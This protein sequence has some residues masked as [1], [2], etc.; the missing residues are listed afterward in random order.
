MVSKTFKLSFATDQLDDCEN[1][2][3]P[4]LISFCG[5]VGVISFSRYPFGFSD[6][7]CEAITETNRSKKKLP[8]SHDIKI[9]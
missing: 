4:S 9:K 8:P 5:K 3:F 6:F 7:I 2:G 1:S